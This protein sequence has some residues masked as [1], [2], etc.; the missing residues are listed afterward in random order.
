M[1]YATWDPAM[2]TGDAQVDEE[3]R[4]MYDLVNEMH[5][6]VETGDD[7]EFVAEA[8]ARVLEYARIH[9]DHEEALMAR[10]G[11]PDL[12]AHRE[13]HREFA[14]EAERLAMEELAGVNFS[15]HGWVGFMADWLEKHI[16]TEDRRIGEYVRR[17]RDASA[18]PE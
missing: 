12:E 5:R 2:E 11:Y 4:A 7:A 15:A 18:H 9:F 10:I 13:L 8:L 1:T 16:E 3:H 17:T 6:R 14:A